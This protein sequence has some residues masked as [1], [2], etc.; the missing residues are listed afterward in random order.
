MKIFRFLLF[1]C[2]LEGKIQGAGGEFIQSLHL[3][4]EAFAN[5]SRR[6]IEEGAHGTDTEHLEPFQHFGRKGQDVDPCLQRGGGTFR[7]IRQYLYLRTEAT[8]FG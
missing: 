2:G 6:K 3:R 1:L 5:P 8:R 7:F 4:T